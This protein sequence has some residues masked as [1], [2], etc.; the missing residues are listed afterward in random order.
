LAFGRAIYEILPGGDV[1]FVAIKE[2]KLIM[3]TKKFSSARQ[4]LAQLRGGPLTFGGMIE[5]LREAD[6]ISQVELARRLKISRAQLCDI[7]KGRRAIAP[8][9][10]LS[11]Q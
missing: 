9:A 4:Y 1:S 7:E 5:S 10:Q 8:D 3:S 6:G 11:S 2:V